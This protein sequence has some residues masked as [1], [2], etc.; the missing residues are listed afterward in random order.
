M[1]IYLCSSNWMGNVLVLL[2]KLQSQE[3]PCKSWSA[4]GGRQSS[5]CLFPTAPLPPKSR[6]RGLWK[7]WLLW[8]PR[9]L[10]ISHLIS[11][12]PGWFHDQ[13]YMSFDKDWRTLQSAL[14]SA[15]SQSD[16]S[17]PCCGPSSASA[18]E[19]GVCLNHLSFPE[20]WHK[21]CSRC[22]P[23]QVIAHLGP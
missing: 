7:Q 8:S 22:D 21:V 15:T 11:K 13:K 10:L 2:V 16:E 5:P 3:L 9:P 6:V 4:A 14:S 1:Q 20:Q 19:V 17:C 23:G 18:R 12:H